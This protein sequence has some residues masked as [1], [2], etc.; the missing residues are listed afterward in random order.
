MTDENERAVIGSNSFMTG[1]ALTEFLEESYSGDL[2]RVAEILEV[3]VKYLAINND[4]DDAAATEFMVSVRTRLKEAEAA[5]VKEKA[6]FL[7]GG[8]RVDGF[9]NTQMLD[10]LERRPSKPNEPFDPLEREDLGLGIRILRAQTIYK[11][12]KLKAEQDRLAAEARAR[13]EEE[14]R[15]AKIAEDARLEAEAAAAKAARARNPEKKAEAAATAQRL[16]EEAQQAEQVLNTKAEERSLA[17]SAAAA[18]AADKTRARGERGGVSS[19]KSWI[20]VRDVDREAMSDQIKRLCE[21]AKIAPDAITLYRLLPFIDV[22]VLEK[23]VS[24]WV[25]SNKATAES[26]VKNKTQPFAGAVI[27]ENHKTAGRA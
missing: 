5:R 25:K 27:F 7:D 3:G 14:A 20:D 18:P 10:P 26:H 22:T 2:K 21:K 11:V 15:A 4:E 12:A 19:L 1:D 13:R 6:P 8:G 24:D 23:A 16:N 9:F 17:V